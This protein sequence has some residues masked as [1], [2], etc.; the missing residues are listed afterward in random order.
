MVSPTDPAPISIEPTYEDSSYTEP[1]M[2]DVDN[3]PDY[4]QYLNSDILLPRDGEYLQ[5]ARV[6][7]RITEDQGN[8]I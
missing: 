3:I 6:V 4:D 2:V 1:T 8:P 5:S 7:R